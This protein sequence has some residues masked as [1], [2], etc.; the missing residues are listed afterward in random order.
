ME[1][2]FNSKKKNLLH[3]ACQEKKIEIQ[4][5]FYF[6]FFLTFFLKKKKKLNLLISHY[7]HPQLKLKTFPHSRLQ[8]G[9]LL[10]VNKQIIDSLSVSLTLS[11]CA[12][13]TVRDDVGKIKSRSLEERSWPRLVVFYS[14]TVHENL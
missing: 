12:L 9:K 6:C 7:D 14:H 8:Q 3:G 4:L 11:F 10:M 5:N 13:C 1:L 2:L